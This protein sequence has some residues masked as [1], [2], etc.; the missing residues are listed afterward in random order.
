MREER[1]PP[2]EAAALGAGDRAA[3]EAARAGV[4]GVDVLSLER[5][6]APTVFVFGGLGFG[7]CWENMGKERKKKR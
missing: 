4:P 2:D 6:E 1:P 5:D 7:F 3:A